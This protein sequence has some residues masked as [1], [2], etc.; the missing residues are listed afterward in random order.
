MKRLLF[1]INPN[2]GKTAV[3]NDLFEI[4]VTFSNAGYEVVTYTTTGPADA[5][6]KVIEEGAKFDLI[7]CAGGD[8]T[9]ENTVCGYMKMGTKKVP[10]GYI[11]AGTTNDF[12][13]SL[14]I[15][16]K[17]CEAAKQI[18]NGSISKIDVGRLEQKYF[19]YIAA[20]GVFTDISYNTKQ[21][22][23]KIM[24]H[25]AYLIEAIKKIANI[26]SYVIEAEFDGKTVTGEYIYG[27]FTNSHSVAGFKIRGVKHVV[28]D[29]GRFDC[30]LVKKPQNPSQLQQILSAVI[31]NDFEESEMFF[32]FNA[33]SI[34]IKSETPIPWTLDGEFGGEFTDTKIEVE[35]QALELYTDGAYGIMG[36]EEYA[37]TYDSD[38][39]D[40]YYEESTDSWD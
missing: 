1:I 18:I 31:M 22:L 16:R 14:R 24:G 20:F 21:S 26:K 7:V 29:D 39:F 27:M 25:S 10:L 40:E 38:E 37:A 4:I 36:S 5:E 23:K 33:S 17:P 32:R 28:L 30:L 8:G 11:P 6:R 12:A 13:R 35:K 9:M 2:A 19:I 34:Q 15:S 3:K